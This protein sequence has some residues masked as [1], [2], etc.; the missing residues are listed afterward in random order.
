MN[1]SIRPISILAGRFASLPPHIRMEVAL[2]LLR[3]LDKAQAAQEAGD[4]FAPD[5]SKKNLLEQFRDEVEAA[6]GEM[7]SPANLLAL[8]D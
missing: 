4:E 8:A 7:L 6:Y 2:K 5:A 1:I 3:W